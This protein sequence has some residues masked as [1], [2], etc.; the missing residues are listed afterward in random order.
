MGIFGLL[1]AMLAVTR[2][3]GQK[4]DGLSYMTVLIAAAVGIGMGFLET[5]VDNFGHIGG[6]IG[7]LLLG[8][9]FCGSKKE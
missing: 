5:G 6:F 8:A 2:K 1:A 3:T 9:A 4:M 7:G